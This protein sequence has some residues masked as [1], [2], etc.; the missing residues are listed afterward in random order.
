MRPRGEPAT[1]MKQAPYHWRPIPLGPGCA[2]LG[3]RAAQHRQRHRPIRNGDAPAPCP[4]LL[5]RD[6]GACPAGAAPPGR[7]R[8]CPGRHAGGREILDRPPPGGPARAALPRCRYRNRGGGRPA[9]HR[10]LRPLRRGAFPRRRTPGD[11]P[12]AG[13][14]ADRAGDRRRRLRRYPHPRR[15]PP[16]RRRLGLAAMPD[17]DP[18]EAGRRARAPADVPQCRSG[19]GAE[20]ADAGAP[21]P[22]C[23]GRYRDPLFRREPRTH[24]PPGAAG[25]GALAA[26]R[27]AAGHPG[28]AQLRHPGGRRA[29]GP[30][31]GA[32]RP[33]AAGPPGRHRHRR[34]R[35][36]A[37]PAGPTGR[38]AGGRLRH[39]RRDH[40]AA[41]RGQQGLSRVAIGAGADAGSRCRPADGG[42]GARRRGGRRPGRIRR[43]RRAARPALRADADHPAGPGGQQRRRQDRR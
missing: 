26:A 25:A 29:A 14:P 42:A 16:V 38:A 10:N 33:G 22:L 2:S 8:N 27:P 37:A 7:A 24:H 41:G 9:H 3:H 5:A 31:R 20:P 13:R 15:H 40:R 34:D 32:A 28:R 1:A 36:A 30:R 43:R 23:R 17:P 12:P 4:G 21:P 39:R 35:R 11:L 19:R 18:A 6:G